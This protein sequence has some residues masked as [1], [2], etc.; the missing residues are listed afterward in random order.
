M[1]LFFLNMTTVKYYTLIISFY[2][3]LASENIG[4]DK[5]KLNRKHLKFLN[6]HLHNVF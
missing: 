2:Y 3:T 1:L 6:I 4:Q 5:Y